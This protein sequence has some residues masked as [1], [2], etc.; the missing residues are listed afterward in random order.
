MEAQ[1]TTPNLH[2]TFNLGEKTQPHW[3]TMNN[4][5]GHIKNNL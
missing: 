2:G 5:D 3:M 1:T 4:K